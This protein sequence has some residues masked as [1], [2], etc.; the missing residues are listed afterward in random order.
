MAMMECAKT[1]EANHIIG[2]S[3]HGS[4]SMLIYHTL[5][6]YRSHPKAISASNNAL[7]AIN[8]ELEGKSAENRLGSREEFPI[9]NF[10]ADLIYV[11]AWLINPMDLFNLLTVNKL[12]ATFLHRSK[13]EKF[14]Q[15]Y[16]AANFPRDFGP[17]M[18]SCK[19]KTVQNAK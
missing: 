16:Y 6:Q 19:A 11:I 8:K 3:L 10:P 17:K 9:Y 15:S 5:P 13:N 1:G 4:F 18:I 14:W 2:N 12:L 7:Y